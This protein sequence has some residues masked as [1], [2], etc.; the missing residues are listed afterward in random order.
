MTTWDE[1]ARTAQALLLQAEELCCRA[2]ELVGA[3]GEAVERLRRARC[4]LALLGVEPHVLADERR[5]GR[6][7]ASQIM[8]RRVRYLR[9]DLLAYLHGRRTDREGQ[10]RARGPSGGTANDVR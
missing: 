6:I 5:R 3:S 2:R 1:L 7:G 9:E 10:G 4:R 8:K